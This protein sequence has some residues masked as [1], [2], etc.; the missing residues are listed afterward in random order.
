VSA[1]WP[2]I[3]VDSFA[4]VFCGA[5]RCGRSGAGVAFFSDTPAVGPVS[6]LIE[7]PH[8]LAR[9]GMHVKLATRPSISYCK[10]IEE[11]LLNLLC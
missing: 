4:M 2:C 11:S 10:E 9:T 5:F 6:T 8:T 3:N 1:D 7:Y